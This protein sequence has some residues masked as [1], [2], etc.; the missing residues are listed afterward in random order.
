MQQ[1]FGLL[2][3]V[4]MPVAIALFVVLPLAGIALGALALMCS[5]RRATRWDCRLR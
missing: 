3:D 4:A 1:L 5:V 2:L